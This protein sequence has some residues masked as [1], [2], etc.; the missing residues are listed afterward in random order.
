MKLS[1][2]WH[3]AVPAIRVHNVPP[4][5]ADAYIIDMARQFA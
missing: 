2:N 3:T 4:G 1:I 5:I